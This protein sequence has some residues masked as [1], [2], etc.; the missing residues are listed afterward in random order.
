MSPF[1]KKFLPFNSI[2]YPLPQEEKN[3]IILR[4]YININEIFEYRLSDSNY[5]CVDSIK[6]AFDK[7]TNTEYVDLI[8][9]PIPL[10]SRD[11]INS[12]DDL[13]NFCLNNYNVQYGINWEL[14]IYLTSKNL[15]IG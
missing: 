12:F 4:H 3:V 8:R 13:I 14:A 11:N 9:K 2:Q 15:I 1:T 6:Q 10:N 7:L 5:N